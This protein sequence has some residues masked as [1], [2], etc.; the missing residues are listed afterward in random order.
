MNGR[1]SSLKIFTAFLRLGLTA[2]GLVAVHNE[3]EAARRRVFKL[4]EPASARMAEEINRTLEGLLAGSG[5]ALDEL[6]AWA[7]RRTARPG[8]RLE[9]FCRRYQATLPF[10]LEHGGGM[11]L[12]REQAHHSS[13]KKLEFLHT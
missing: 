5:P 8:S 11:L 2:F 13:K 7:R 12:P 3:R 4:Y 1:I 6:A 10:A 9:E